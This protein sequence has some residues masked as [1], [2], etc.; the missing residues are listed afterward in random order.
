MSGQPRDGGFDL[1]R[2]GERIRRLRQGSGTSLSAVAR[3]LGIS[4]SAL[5]Q[6]ETGALQP[7]VSRLVE[8]VGVLGVP[9]SAVFDEDAAAPAPPPPGT[10]QGTAA[11]GTAALGAAHG[12][13]PHGGRAA[14]EVLV[15]VAVAR[16]VR[17]AVVDL[18]GGVVYRR[19][20]PRPVPGVEFFESTYPPGAASGEEGT[21]LVH[22]GLET[23]VVT[24]GRLTFQFPD[25]EVELAEGDS[26]SFPAD[27]GHRI[28]NRT[29]AVAVSTWLTVATC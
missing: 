19:L 9:L 4:P 15:S 16:A 27:R 10:A 3:R 17:P 8:I 29:R 24:A 14:E 28:V 2:L 20:T 11:Q 5:S 26:I 25:G 18:G 21:L 12:R 22:T 23:G 6:I 1:D 13:H 7:S